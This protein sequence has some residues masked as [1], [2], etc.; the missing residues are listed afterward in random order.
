MSSVEELI[1]TLQKTRAEFTQWKDTLDLEAPMK[2]RLVLVTQAHR[3]TLPRPKTS[4]ELKQMIKYKKM[5]R[6][7]GAR[8]GLFSATSIIKPVT[9]TPWQ[10]A[11]AMAPNK[12]FQAPAGSK[13]IKVPQVGGIFGAPPLNHLSKRYRVVLSEI[14]EKHKDYVQHPSKHQKP[15]SLPDIEHP[16]R[17][18]PTG[19]GIGEFKFET[20]HMS[21]PHST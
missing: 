20:A 10:M 2:H 21:P 9:L 3:K 17:W 15:L 4:E 11:K 5:W 12:C 18:M 16:R 13:P 19:T 8:A 1:S 6:D 14:M 7:A